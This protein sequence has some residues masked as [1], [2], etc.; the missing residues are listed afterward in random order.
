LA[1]KRA[2]LLVLGLFALLLCAGCVKLGES[3]ELPLAAVEPTAI[4]ADRINCQEILGTAFRSDEERAW[5]MENC[6]KWPL[7]KVADESG[8]SAPPANSEPPEC[9]TI[10]GKPYES[11]Q[12]R[13]WYLQN[14]NQQNGQPP[15]APQQ[16]Q[17]PANPPA[18]AQTPGGPDRTDCNAIRGTPYRSDNERNWYNQN[19]GNNANVAPASGGP[20]RTDC[21]AIRG[22]AYRSPAERDWYNA[23]CRGG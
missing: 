7:V 9:T 1:G 2:F 14:C 16:P 22:T 4:P 21:N 13:T 3:S 18:Q 11:S 15:A 20:D 23:N 6:S 8:G 5:F 10:R 17:P 12:Q 19:C